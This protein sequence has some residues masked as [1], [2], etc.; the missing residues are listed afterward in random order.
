MALN[1]RNDNMRGIA[2]RRH[3]SVVRKQRA[4]KVLKG[5]WRY[6]IELHGTVITPVD[7]GKQA[8]VPHPCDCCCRPNARRFEG[9]TI[10]ELRQID[11]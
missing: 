3:K 7:V 8:E 11:V 4:K 1:G 5:W 6:G 9:M 2:Y 10:Q